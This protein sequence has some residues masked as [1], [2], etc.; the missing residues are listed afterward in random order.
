M[1]MKQHVNREKRTYR[2]LRYDGNPFGT[3]KSRQ[4]RLGM[5]YEFLLEFTVTPCPSLRVMRMEGDE[6]HRSLAPFRMLSSHDGDFEHVGVSDK[7]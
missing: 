2:Q 6:N 1:D 3:G 5:L 4:S 7:F